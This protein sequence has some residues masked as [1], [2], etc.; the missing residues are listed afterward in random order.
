MSHRLSLARACRDLGWKVVVA[1]RV[2]R[3]G[4]AILN[5]GFKLIPIGMRRGGRRPIH[6][7]ST[8]LEMVLLYARERPDI[9]HHV[10]LKP[11]IYGSLAA[12]MTS[13]GLVVNAL[14]G[15]G[16][17]FTSSRTLIRMVRRLIKVLLKV[18]LSSRR[19]WLIVQNQ[20]DASMLLA[21]GIA[22]ANHTKIIKGSGVDLERFVPETEPGGEIIVALVGRMLEDKGVRE[23]V[24]AARELRRRGSKI[25]IWLVGAPDDENPTSISEQLLVCW[26][27]EGCVRWLGHQDDV[28]SVWSKAHIS[29]HP[30]YREGMPLALLEAAACG[31]PMVATDI[32]GCNDF[33]VDGVNG[34]LVPKKDWMKLAD[35]IETLANSGD[36]RA[37]FGT[38]AR[39]QVEAGY[40]QQAVADQTIALYRKGINEIRWKPDTCPL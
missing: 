18:C 21:N 27:E 33:V 28:K 26:Q 13:T 2:E 23:A 4:E 29:I 6:E 40:G 39:K 1:T 35:C 15:M 3:H 16:Y 31:K 5:E 38:A 12:M 24:L 8:M 22:R 9:M 7:F 32:P 14:M 20:H 30:S 36:L 25:Q 10:G 19:H 17:I 34:F 37:R 11:V